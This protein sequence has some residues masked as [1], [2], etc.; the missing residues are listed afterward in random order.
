MRELV[1]TL[2]N[3]CAACGNADTLLAIHLPVDIR[4][5]SARE[6]VQ[7]ASKS[8]DND[9]LTELESIRHYLEDKR[10]ILILP[11]IDKATVTSGISFYPNYI[12]YIDSDFYDVLAV[13]KKM[14]TK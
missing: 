10:T 2:D 3:A 14:V 4:I 1:N 9:E 7:P 13:L 8:A 12:S 11:N 5:K 6:S